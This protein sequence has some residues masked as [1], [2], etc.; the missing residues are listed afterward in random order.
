M[1][2]EST[3]T[4]DANGHSAKGSARKAATT[5]EAISNIA[6][7]FQN[8]VADIEDLIQST[9]SLDGEDLSQA[10]AK[11]HARVTAAK[12]SIQKIGHPLVDRARSTVKDAGSYVN[13]RPW[14]SVGMAVGVS[15]LVGYLLGRRG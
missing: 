9:T 4:A 10:R 12:D 3:P 7:E 8:F 14:Q 6:R 1:R 13:Q 5:N 15:L 11:L 2:T